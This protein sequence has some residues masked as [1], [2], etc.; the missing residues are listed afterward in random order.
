[1]SLM[2]SDAEKGAALEYIYRWRLRHYSVRSLLLDRPRT[3]SRKTLNKYRTLVCIKGT[4]QGYN[5]VNTRQSWWW[6]LPNK[7]GY[8]GPQ[9]WV[10]RG[11]WFHSRGPQGGDSPACTW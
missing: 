8:T 2:N 10:G 3:M 7:I 4:S 6:G 9:L 5:R 11:L 1:M